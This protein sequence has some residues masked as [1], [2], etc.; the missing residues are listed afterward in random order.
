MFRREQEQLLGLKQTV[1]GFAHELVGKFLASRHLR[2]LLTNPSSPDWEEVLNL[3]GEPR[4][5]EACFFAMDE[6]PPGGKLLDKF[7]QD[8][9]LRGGPLRLRLAAYALGTRAPEVISQEVRAAYNQ[10]KMAEDLRETP[11][12][13]ALAGLEFPIAESIPYRG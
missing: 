2:T 1:I 6:L 5:L 11:A 10:A 7:L 4:W 12:S 3:T 13:I 9:V 8:L